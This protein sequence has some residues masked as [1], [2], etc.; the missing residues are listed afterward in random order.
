MAIDVMQVTHI[1]AARQILRISWDEAWHILCRAVQRGLRRKEPR[2]IKHMGVD[3][4]AIARGQKYFTLVCDQ[5]RGTVEHIGDGRDRRSF[6][7]Y[8]ESLTPEQLE[9][10]VAIAMDMHEAY[11]Q[12]ALAKIPDAD[13]KIVFDL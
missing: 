7:A 11:V 12:A 2:L 9:A 13:Q 1:K 4:K 10:I 5:D 8:L 3:E 6:E